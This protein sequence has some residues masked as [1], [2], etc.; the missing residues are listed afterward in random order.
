M[1]ASVDYRFRPRYRGLVIGVIALAIAL[2]AFGALEAGRGG[3][4]VL[5]T[6]IVGLLLGALY[7]LSPVWRMRVRVNAGGLAVLRGRAGVP[8]FQ[9]LWDEIVRVVAS[10][11]TGTCFVNGGGPDRSLMVPGPGASAPYDIEN[12]SDLYRTI[13]ARVAPARI[14]WVDLIETARRDEIQ[15]A[16]GDGGEPETS[17]PPR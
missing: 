2:I 1:D 3:S 13:I 12:K 17:A 7:L 9:L 6:G 4:Y 16:S 15:R 10:E 11:E 8:R 5:I 14:Q